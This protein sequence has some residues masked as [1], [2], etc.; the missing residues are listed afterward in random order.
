MIFI[1]LYFLFILAYISVTDILTYRI[2]N[3]LLLALLPPLASHWLQF[4]LTAASF[5]GCLHLLSRIP[6]SLFL[7]LFF[8]F[9]QFNGGDCKLTALFSLFNDLTGI[10]YSLFFAFAAS[11]LF[12]RTKKTTTL[13]LG[14]FLVLG[15]LLFYL[16]R[17]M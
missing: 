15:F 6:I 2:P 12:M 9:L 10:L 5:S 13:P 14:P 4:L 16:P 7:L 3:R 8:R 1:D 11:L 17:S